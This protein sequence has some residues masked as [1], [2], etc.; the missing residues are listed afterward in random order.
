MLTTRYKKIF[1]RCLEPLAASLARLGV[2]PS[3]ITLSAFLLAMLVCWWFVRTE[4]VI[5]FCI[6]I[7]LVGC[8][9]GLDG[10]VARFSGRVTKFGGYLDAVCDRGMEAIVAVSVAWVTGYWL[11]V[12][13]VLVGA[14]LVSYAKARAAME[15][16]VS[17]L[18][19]PDLMERTERGVVF[20][21][22]LTLSEL[23]S[24][25]PMGHDLFWWALV[26]LIPLVYLTVIQRI[27]RARRYIQERTTR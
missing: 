5:P 8:L 10:A 11:L 2:S 27:L 3:A 15:V 16:A 18:E 21:A 26:L 22:G 4:A 9:D 1:N 12:S 23:V 20:L 6:A 19:W 24:W 17:N 25:Q 14:F 13:L 7:A